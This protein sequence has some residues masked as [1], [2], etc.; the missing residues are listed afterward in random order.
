[1]IS[2]VEI[3]DSRE[4]LLQRVVEFFS[5][6]DGVLGVLLVG[7][8]PG[9][10]ADAYSDID[11]RVF[12]TP[13]SHSDFLQKRLEAPLQWGE[14]LFNEWIEGSQ[15]CVSHF[16]P[17]LK[18]DVIY[19]NIDEVKPSTWFN[20]PATIL[21]DYNESVQ[22]FLS[23]CAATRFDMP[24]SRE[25]SR[26]ISKALAYAHETLRKSRRQESYYA[27][28]L[29]ERLRTHVIEIEDWITPFYPED[30]KRLKL[31]AR[32]SSRLQCVLKK[33]YPPLD[34][35][36]IEQSLIAVCGLLRDQIID[37]HSA[38]TLDRVLETD[39]DAVELIVDV[40][41]VHASPKVQ[42]A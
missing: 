38:F 22:R 9:G 35:A 17:F 30:A 42:H 6:Q 36:K 40:K 8:I 26:T 14:L 2:L 25:V 32:I 3:E 1:V 33:A 28:S 31:E 4:R 29:L 11:I 18:I 24:T 19:L 7:S 27:Q 34:S 16:E 13:E 41:I 20:L 10:S 23:R 5:K 37:L 12:T 39:V 15:V 21:F